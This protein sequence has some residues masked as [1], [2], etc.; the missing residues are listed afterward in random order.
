MEFENAFV[1]AS[2]ELDDDDDHLE[3]SPAPAA[4]SC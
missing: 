3:R 2:K 4:K 1:S